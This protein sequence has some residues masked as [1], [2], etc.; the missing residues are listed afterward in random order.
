MFD[1]MA[2]PYG[3]DNDGYLPVHMSVWAKTAI[4]WLECQV[5]DKSGTFALE[6]AALSPSCLKIV[7][8]AADESMTGLEEYLLVENRQQIMFDVDFWG[9]GVVIYHVDEDADEQYNRGYPGQGGWPGN[10]VSTITCGCSRMKSFMIVAVLTLS[11]S[12]LCRIITN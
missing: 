3:F 8:V 12:F 9:S 6:P 1:I 4:D 11:R 2:Y 5:V 10:G 7:L